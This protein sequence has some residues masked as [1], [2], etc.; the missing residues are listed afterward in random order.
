MRYAIVAF[1]PAKM[2]LAYHHAVVPKVAGDGLACRVVD[3]VNQS[4]ELAFLY[5]GSQVDRRFQQAISSN[6]RGCFPLP[7]WHSH[8][9]KVVSSAD[10]V[11]RIR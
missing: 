11:H 7:D 10:S 3:K 8:C 5:L 6:R 2:A 9:V 4:C 1:D